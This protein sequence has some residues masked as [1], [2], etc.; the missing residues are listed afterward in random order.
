MIE[1]AIFWDEVSDMNVGM[2]AGSQVCLGNI[3]LCNIRMAELMPN[4]NLLLK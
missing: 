1:V 2:I 3:H 4:C